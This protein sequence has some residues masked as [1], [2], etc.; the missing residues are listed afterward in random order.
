MTAV[1]L[2][3]TIV[4]ERSDIGRLLI[5]W[6]GKAFVRW[7][8]SCAGTVDITGERNVVTD[9][10]KYCRAE[11]LRRMCQFVGVPS[12]LLESE[13]DRHRVLGLVQNEEDLQ[14]ANTYPLNAA[15][16]PESGVP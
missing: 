16:G 11:I 15:A 5:G 10:V 8:D 13:V 12:Q 4:A 7:L 3:A 1:G 6:R 9:L 14:V 2:L